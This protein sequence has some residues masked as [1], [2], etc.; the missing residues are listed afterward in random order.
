[1]VLFYEDEKKL[2]PPLTKTRRRL[3]LALRVVLII[4]AMFGLSLVFMNVLGGSSDS[5][6]AG[7]QDYL[8]GATG[9]Q[10]DI[11]RFEGVTFFPE[12]GIA[13]GD[14]TFRLDAGATSVAT[15]GSLNLVMGF[16]DIFFRLGRIRVLEV[17]DAHFDADVITARALEIKR[18]GIDIY[19]N[20][21]GAARLAVEG[22]YGGAP[23][24]MTVAMSADDI[25]GGRQAF[26]L[27]GSSAITVDFLFLKMAG[28]M[29][30]A[31][32]GGL[33][34][35]FSSIG[36]SEDVVKGQA[37][38]KRGRD[39]INLTLDLA[40]VAGVDKAAAA[41]EK[42]YCAFKPSGRTLWKKIRIEMITV[43]GQPQKIPGEC[44]AATAQP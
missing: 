16:W 31:R 5:L 33:L 21:R 8:R 30:R 10:A 24:S 12:A 32:G 25:G 43:D 26:R 27:S 28:T 20:D 13:V 36:T 9:L 29:S 42:I 2:K 39:G 17:K 14:V 6:R 11:G 34:F 41:L 23:F 7:V 38:L 22:V 4:G 15:V 37:V 1:M 18:I 19:E 35:D 44:P 40:S 3:R